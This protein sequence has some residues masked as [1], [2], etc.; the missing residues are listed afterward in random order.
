M[1][2]DELLTVSQ[3]V[4]VVTEQQQNSFNY[5]NIIWSSNNRSLMKVLLY[6]I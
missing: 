1:T 2:T 6:K 5:Q 4:T 3:I